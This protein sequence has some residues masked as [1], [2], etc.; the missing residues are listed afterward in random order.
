MSDLNLYNSHA[1][2]SLLG[3]L[4]PE[5]DVTFIS[6]QLQDGCVGMLQLFSTEGALSIAPPGDFLPS[7]PY[8]L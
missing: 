2:A 6:D 3:K 1:Q 5:R 8:H 4:L 7:L